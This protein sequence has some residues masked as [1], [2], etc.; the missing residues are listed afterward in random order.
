MAIS[1]KTLEVH[2]IPSAGNDFFKSASS[3]DASNTEEILAA[4]ARSTHYVSKIHIKC[5]PAAASIVTVSIGSGETTG[6]LTT[7]HL[8]LIP[9]SGDAGA[10]FY[11]DLGKKGIK[12]VEGQA[13]CIDASGAGLVHVYLEG[14]TCKTA[15]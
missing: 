15:Y 8:D 10:E 5:C 11:L 4:V 6:A 9:F 1:V 12:F 7:A 3:V 2:D 14:R 13:I